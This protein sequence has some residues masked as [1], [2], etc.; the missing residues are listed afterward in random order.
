MRRALVL[1]ARGMGSTSPN[2]MVG[3]VLVRRGRV[4]GWGW[5][6]RAGEN[7][8]E[9]EAVLHARRRGFTARG[10]TLYVTLEP[11]CTQGRTP[12]C[13]QFIIAQRIARVVAGAQ[14]PNPKHR[15]R[16]FGLLRRAGID[17]TQ[18]VLAEACERLNEAFSHWITQQTP[19]VTVKAA[20]TLDGKVATANGESKWITSSVARQWG[21]RLRMESDA[22]LVGVETVRM[23]DPSLTVRLRGAR[24]KAIRRIILDS[25]A[26][27][28]LTS[29]VIGDEHAALT[30]VVVTRAAPARRVKALSRRVSVVLAPKVAAG[31]DLRW[32]LARL[33]AEGVTRL[34]VEGGGTVHAS[35]LRER[36]A[37]RIVFFYAPKILGGRDARRAVGG[38][39][40]RSLTEALRLEGVR[41][42][43]VGPDLMLTARMAVVLSARPDVHRHH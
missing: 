28:P 37:Q 26:R 36:L 2:P 43:R 30:T 15:G 24:K 20:M 3:A 31:V 9:R 1:A 4:L 21:H 18:G 29:R 27:T 6:A 32:L 5:H 19:L 14:D 23:D 38:A 39:G 22:V 42:R 40:A 35:F 16:G 7:H 41:W 8:A 33:G 11:C 34:L 25:R 10:A 13:T 12:P 17:V